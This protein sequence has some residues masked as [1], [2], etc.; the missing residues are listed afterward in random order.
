MAVDEQPTSVDMLIDG[1]KSVD[2]SANYRWH[3][4]WEMYTVVCAV[5]LH[6]LPHSDASTT[7]SDMN[8]S[9]C[10]TGKCS[11]YCHRANPP[12]DIRSTG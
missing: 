5:R 8:I 11:D 10:G 6:L 12:Y 2:N 3:R 7:S 1:G 4:S 9:M